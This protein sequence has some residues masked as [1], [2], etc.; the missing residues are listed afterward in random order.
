MKVAL[1]AV[2][3]ALTMAFCTKEK[4]VR[5]ASGKAWPFYYYTYVGDNHNVFQQQ[6][7]SYYVMDENQFPDCLNTMGHTTCSIKA[8]GDAWIEG[9]PDMS[10]IQSVWYR[11]L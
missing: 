3:A 11:P 8:M 9:Q 2:A 5:R 6:D 7:A 4:E 1:I 10:T